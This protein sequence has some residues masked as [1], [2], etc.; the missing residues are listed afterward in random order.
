ME[1]SN[2]FL[3]GAYFQKN[4][5]AKDIYDQWFEKGKFNKEEF[6][7]QYPIDTE[8]QEIVDEFELHEQWKEKSGLR[9]TPTVL[10]NGYSLPDNFKIEDIRYVS[11]MDIK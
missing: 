6:F 1:V 9:A 5:E 3:I 2:K 7:K 11:E 8:A 4:G 10:V